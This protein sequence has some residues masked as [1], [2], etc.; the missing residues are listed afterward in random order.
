MA[1]RVHGIT[2][3][4]DGSGGVIS[5]RKVAAHLIAIA[6]PDRRPSGILSSQ[7][8]ET[9]GVHMLNLRLST[10]AIGLIV[11]VTASAVVLANGNEVPD[12]QDNNVKA[13]GTPASYYNL[14]TAPLNTNVTNIKCSDTGN[15]PSICPFFDPVIGKQRIVTE[16]VRKAT[17]G[18]TA[19]QCAAGSDSFKLADFDRT[20][21][22]SG[23]DAVFLDVAGAVTSNGPSAVSKVSFDWS[24]NLR[25]FGEVG[26][27][28]T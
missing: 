23:S 8:I 21:P 11:A 25:F 7:A 15:G 18:P 6:T 10:L 17:Q 4:D 22:Y 13:A 26:L 24:F 3:F 12:P 16:I 9:R 2:D 19:T 1:L 14:S 5:E 27:C 20:R 28:L